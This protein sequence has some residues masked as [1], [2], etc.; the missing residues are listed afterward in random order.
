MRR[1]FCIVLPFFLFL[2]LAQGQTIASKETE[3]IITGF[4]N[5]TGVSVGSLSRNTLTEGGQTWRLFGLSKSPS[6]LSD[7]E[8]KKERQSSEYARRKLVRRLL[9]EQG[10]PELQKEAQKV[11]TP[12]LNLSHEVIFAPNTVSSL[13]Q[14]GSIMLPHVKPEELKRKPQS[15]PQD[16][17]SVDIDALHPASDP[18]N[19]DRWIVVAWT[20]PTYPLDQIT[21]RNVILIRGTSVVS[22]LK[23]RRFQ[24]VHQDFL[25]DFFLQKTSL[26]RSAEKSEALPVLAM[27]TS[28]H[29][30][31][32]SEIITRFVLTSSHQLIGDSRLVSTDPV[33]QTLILAKEFS[34]FK[35]KSVLFYG[36]DLSL[37]NLNHIADET[38]VKLVRRSH[39]ATLFHY[40]FDQPVTVAHSIVQPNS[41]QIYGM[42][43]DLPGDLIN[44][45]RRVGLVESDCLYETGKCK[46]SRL[47]ETQILFEPP[48]S[49]HWVR[50]MFDNPDDFVRLYNSFSGLHDT[51]PTSESCERETKICYTKDS[52]SI[53]L[54][55]GSVEVEVSTSGKISL[56]VSVGSK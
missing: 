33:K 28:V 30:S 23:T 9:D 47:N 53:V 42:S 34:E 4:E 25:S 21:A 11:L 22:D 7:D 26:V 43:Q 17:V 3:G 27:Y 44:R 38:G 48:S 37:I 15:L 13:W 10:D 8:I 55:C 45:L 35:G 5:L 41:F 56:G 19:K 20:D 12:S 50:V 46:L 24:Q 54:S 40:R 1:G 31:T 18:Y 52:A 16:V 49:H 6:N 36:D 51:E 2:S 32:S 29:N 39:E 14:Y